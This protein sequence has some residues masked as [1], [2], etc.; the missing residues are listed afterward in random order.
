MKI[1][2]E[3]KIQKWLEKDY[4]KIRNLIQNT[5]IFYKL[6]TNQIPYF[7]ID[8][9]IKQKVA[10]SAK[11]VYDLLDDVDL[12]I[13]NKNISL[14][15]SERLY[16][17]LLLF[18]PDTSTFFIVEIK[19]GD[20]TERETI[21]EILAY[22]HE[23]KNL[24]PYLSSFEV[25]FVI[26]A[27]DYN[28]LLS[29]SIYSL[30]IWQNKNVLP[31]KID[32]IESENYE[33]WNLS[34]HIP[35]AW[36]LLSQESFNAEN[37]FTVNL[38]LEDKDAYNGKGVDV[39]NKDDNLEILYRGMELIVKDA[40]R[41]GVNGFVLLNRLTSSPLANWCITIGVINPFK[42]YKFTDY[43][44]KIKDFFDKEN[45]SEFTPKC[46]TE[47]A[48]KA[49]KYLDIFYRVYFEN[50]VDWRG[51]KRN[52]RDIT[53]PINIDFFGQ[54][55]D[56]V[57]N[58]ILNKEVR[59][60]YYPEINSQNIDWKK[61]EIGLNI[62]DNI[63]QENI[64][65]DGYFDFQSFYKFGTYLGT[66]YQY[67]NIL[68]T[69]EHLFDNEAFIGKLR[70]VEIEFINAYR[71]LLLFKKS[72]N[73]PVYKSITKENIDEAISN[74]NIIISYFIDEYIDIDDIKSA[75][76]LGLEIKNYFVDNKKFMHEDEVKYIEDT[77]VSYSNDFVENFINKEY[78]ETKELLNDELDFFI[79]KFIYILEN[80]HFSDSKDE[81]LISIF[82]EYTIKIISM[83]TPMLENN[84]VKFNFDDLDINIL[85]ELYIEEYKKSNDVIVLLKQNGDIKIANAKMM[86]KFSINP[87]LELLFRKDMNFTVTSKIKWEELKEQN[88]DFDDK[89]N[90]A[91]FYNSLKKQDYKKDLI[92]LK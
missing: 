54:V 77:I 28:T 39:K 25:C 15:K 43:D 68:K 74:I 73:F 16:P 38:V 27:S 30:S 21:T 41:N 3:D 62:L 44:S 55:D 11:Y 58:F 33:D 42:F 35:K 92:D 61:A 12:V 52:L 37:I 53:I 18:S 2:K 71:E 65:L 36:S 10:K 1:V 45:S 63:L 90:F 24:F 5:D 79:K 4:Q 49:K 91:D 46:V 51:Q 72:D 85:K 64:F 89:I 9:L 32:G 47:I 70:W 40:E 88:L 8:Y 75:F 84:S 34:L 81:Q 86:G 59:D 57:N 48:T 76:I 13:A 60:Y 50:F 19:R 31:I 69:N 14:E 17:D 83:M 7:S 80:N 67:F 26:I 22:E 20:K 6:E 29:H 87:E 23:L 66:I 82:E 56:I 78:K